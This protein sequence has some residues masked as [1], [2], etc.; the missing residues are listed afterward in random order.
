MGGGVVSG[1]IRFLCHLPLGRLKTILTTPFVLLWAILT[2]IFMC[3]LSPLPQWMQR[4]I[5]FSGRFASKW[6]YGKKAAAEIRLRQIPGH[7][8]RGS[9][10][11]IGTGRALENALLYNIILRIAPKVHYVDLVNLSLVSKRVRATMF[12]ISEDNNKDR[13]LRLYSCY[14]NTKS[15]CW[16]CGIQ[17]CNVS[18]MNTSLG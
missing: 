15:T 3:L 14:G 12:P 6:G 16:I 18:F 2:G 5:R 8:P 4:P 10:K 17:I 7:L 1:V 11:R 9:F 13:E